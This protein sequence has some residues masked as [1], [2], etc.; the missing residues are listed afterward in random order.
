M[1]NDTGILTTLIFSV[2]IR[3]FTCVVTSRVLVAANWPTHVLESML[4]SMNLVALSVAVVQKA[5]TTT[6]PLRSTQVEQ[7][8]Q[9][10]EKISVT[11]AGRMA[12]TKRP[13]AP[14]I[15]VLTT[16]SIKK[17]VKGKF[18]SLR[19]TSF[20]IPV[21]RSTL[22]QRIRKSAKHLRLVKLWVP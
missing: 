11:F 15:Q 2:S 5:V 16:G 18:P 22:L 13:F 7:V 14:K 3:M 12:P 9:R 10:R 20:Q 4:R 19:T 8:V 6:L 1:V 17:R 21:D